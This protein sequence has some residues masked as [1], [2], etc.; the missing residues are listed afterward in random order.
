MFA[1]DS[2][3]K[4]LDALI[5]AYAKT[6]RFNG[7]ALVAQR[8]NI[9]LQK[10][11]GLKNDSDNSM[12]DANTK[13][14]IASVTKTF[15]STVVL[16]LVELKKMSLADKLS[17]YY[18]GFP[19]GDS[20]TIENLLTHTSGLRN[21]TEEDSSITETDEQRIVP[22][23][24]T[25][26]PD[27]AP[28]TNWHYSNSGYIILA[29]IIQKV[30]GISYW[31]A[32]HKYIFDPLQMLNSGFDFTHLTGNEKAIGYDVLTDSVKHRSAVTD[33]TVP[34]GAGA[35]YSTVIDMYKWHQ[36]LQSYKI[37]D[38]DLMEKAYTPCALHN[39]GY[40]WQIDSI[41]GK[42]RVSHSGSISGF[43]SNF[44]RIPHDDICIVLLS[45]KSGSTFDVMHITDKLLAVL[46][47]QPYSIPVKRKPVAIRQDVLQKYAGTY[48]IDEM[49]LT[50]DIT[51]GDGILIAQP[52]RDGHPGPTSVIHPFSDIG[53]YDERDEDLEV[54]FDV[55]A[56]GK[57]KDIKILQMGITKYAN[58]I[59]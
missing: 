28:G 56:T 7:S 50:I 57:V 36:G 51:A 18:K 26:K 20:I 29:Y 32:V 2:T 16:K 27:F 6:G 9:L 46:Y 15:T 12:N 31:Q 41:Y 25:L 1:Q 11:Y 14:Q 21:L 52:C 19:Y 10:G 43:G 5:T 48:K 55:D 42:K 13:Y 34:F 40:G 23:L 30:S 39:Y 59:K 24:K 37:V 4:K 38:R 44:A 53:F 35:I 33:S 17:K 8:G 45:N 3:T 58:K 47:H 54:T 22:Y 49:N